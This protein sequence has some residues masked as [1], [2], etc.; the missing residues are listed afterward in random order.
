MKESLREITGHLIH[1]YLVSSFFLSITRDKF[2]KIKG[3]LKY[4]KFKYSDLNDKR[5][6]VRTLMKLFQENILKFVIWR[7]ALSVDEMM[8]K[9]YVKT[10]L[11][12]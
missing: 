12:S 9:T 7:T 2:E 8:D 10:L 6:R 5:W 4:S 11:N 1:V 3:I